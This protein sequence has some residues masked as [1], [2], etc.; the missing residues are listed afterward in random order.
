[1]WC[2]GCIRA[3]CAGGGPSRLH[4]R[5][6]PFRL[7]RP[8]NPGECG[9]GGGL[10]KWIDGVW[11]KLNGAGLQP[12]HWEG[13]SLDAGWVCHMSDWLGQ[14]SVRADSPSTA[15]MWQAKVGEGGTAIRHGKTA[16]MQQRC[17]GIERWRWWGE[18]EERG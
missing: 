14:R 16:C 5:N 12:C 13:V 1:M 4:R 9:D 18:V 17:R 7:C 11:V 15:C 3:H 6:G 8:E 10:E 2:W